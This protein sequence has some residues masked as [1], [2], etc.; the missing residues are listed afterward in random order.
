LSREDDRW[1]DTEP[2]AIG[3]SAPPD[4]RFN[5][6]ATAI[7][8]FAAVSIPIVVV[9]FGFSG[10]NATIVVI[11]VAAGLIAGILAGVWVSQRGG[12]VWRG[13]QL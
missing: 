5:P 12:Q 9:G 6:L 3:P 8:V 2:P 13:P 11:G 4:A 7:G 1:P 10:A